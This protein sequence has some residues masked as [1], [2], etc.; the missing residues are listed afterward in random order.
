M[1][2]VKNVTPPGEVAADEHTVTL[3]A[4]LFVPKRVKDG[5][6][7]ELDLEMVDFWT[8]G[9]IFSGFDSD[10]QVV[11]SFEYE[12]SERHTPAPY[13]LRRPLRLRP[14]KTV[15]AFA[16]ALGVTGGIFL[17]LVWRM[18]K[19]EGDRRRR[20]FALT[21][22]VFIG[23]L[24]S[25]LALQGGLELNVSALNLRASYDKP[26]MLF[27]LS[28]FAT[29]SG[30]PLLKKYL[31]LDGTSGDGGDTSPAPAPTRTGGT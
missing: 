7:L 9:S 23:L 4:P 21:S 18:L 3:K 6:S 5:R 25:I 15:S 24:V 1:A 19:L 2:R 26:F 31:Q 20:W 27:I 29:I 11:V 22:T 12:D 8:G 17:M 16:I 28:L 10:A 14:S 13:V 30:T